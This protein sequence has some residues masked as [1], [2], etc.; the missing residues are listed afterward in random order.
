MRFRRYNDDAT[1]IPIVNHIVNSL[2][3]LVLTAT[4]VCRSFSVSA[5]IVFF[6]DTGLAAI[7]NQGRI[8]LC[9]LFASKRLNYRL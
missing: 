6:S 9:N 1:Y 3:L 8:L 5:W 2:L 7:V 4:T